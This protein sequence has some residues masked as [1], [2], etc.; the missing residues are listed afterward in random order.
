M[1]LIQLIISY[2]LDLF[3]CLDFLV[4]FIIFYKNPKF[5][6]YADIYRKPFLTT[7]FDDYLKR[8]RAKQKHVNKKS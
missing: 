8:V 7:A 5:L 6:I 4:D 1:S 3:F 2:S